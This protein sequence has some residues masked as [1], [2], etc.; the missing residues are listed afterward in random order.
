MKLEGIW[1]GYYEYGAGYPLPHFGERVKISVTFKGD[2]EDFIGVVSEEES[3]FSVPYKATLQGFCEEHIISFV[4]TYPVFPRIEEDGSTKM[5]YEERELDITHQGF[6]DSV[7]C[8]IYGSWQVEDIYVD[9]KGK[10]H[11]FV[12][13]GIWLLKR[14]DENG[15]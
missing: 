14:N 5:I 15:A 13:D 12:C 11:D 10:K 4:K 3:E 1:E 2:N 6:I 9:E 8:S 7:F